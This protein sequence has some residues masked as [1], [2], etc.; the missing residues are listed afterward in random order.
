MQ[1][2]KSIVTGH[3]DSTHSSSLQILHGETLSDRKLVRTPN[4]LSCSFE[5]CGAMCCR[6]WSC[7]DTQSETKTTSFDTDLWSGASLLLLLHCCL[8]HR[9]IQVR[10][11]SPLQAGEL[12]P[13]HAFQ[14]KSC[15]S[16]SHATPVSGASIETKQGGYAWY[17]WVIF[18]W[19]F[20]NVSREKKI[21]PKT[22]R[23]TCPGTLMD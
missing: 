3:E 23:S 9:N 14:Q 13:T 11:Y 10:P 2:V 15:Y 16:R 8:S 1:F 7:S 5:S 18:S 6:F 21:S 12:F 19:I 22:Q 4:F 20:P 17:T